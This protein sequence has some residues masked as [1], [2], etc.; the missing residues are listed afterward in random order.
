VVCIR[1]EDDEWSAT[2]RICGRLRLLP[3]P[4]SAGGTFQGAKRQ[5]HASALTRWLIMLQIP[6]DLEGTSQ[7]GLV[8]WRG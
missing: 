3:L 1:D 2:S 7:D 4:Y 5:Q 6:K 8:Q